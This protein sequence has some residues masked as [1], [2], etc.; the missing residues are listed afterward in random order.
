MKYRF[1]PGVTYIVR[2]RTGSQIKARQ[3][4]MTYLS[5]DADRKVHIFNARPAAGTQALRDEDILSK[6]PVGPRRGGR[7]NAAHYMNQMV[8]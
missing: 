8:K 5:W 4:C 1:E 7:E 2:T 6:E 3:H